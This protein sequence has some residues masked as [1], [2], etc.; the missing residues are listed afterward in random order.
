MM[1]Q[2]PETG[3]RIEIVGVREKTLGSELHKG[4]IGKEGVVVDWV[5]KE[6]CEVWLPVI[7][8][9]DIKGTVCHGDRVWWK[10]I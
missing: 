4:D 7:I 10:R 6:D 3:F 2:K 5:D 1:V 8:L 9:Y